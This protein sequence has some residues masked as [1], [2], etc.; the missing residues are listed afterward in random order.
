[1]KE[2]DYYIFIDFSEDL[3]GYDIINHDKMVELLP[4]ISKFAHYRDLRHKK[5][6]LKSIKKRIDREKILSFFLEY[7]IK[8]LHSNADIYA[9]VL[10]FIKNH[11]NCIIFISVDNRQFAA[12]KKLVGIIDAEKIVVKKE[13]E[14]I[15]GTPEYQV[16][17]VLDTL[18]NIKRN[19]P[20]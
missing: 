17:L 13:S 1:M 14:L 18:L 8:E 16:S 5:E 15:K 19:E 9:D 2:F 7:K 20:R 10:Q 4:R 3:I 11:E 12:F 6:Y